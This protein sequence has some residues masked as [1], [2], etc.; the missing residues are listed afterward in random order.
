MAWGRGIDVVVSVVKA[1]T[2]GTAA[3]VNAANL[4]IRV[5]NYTWADGLE[6][7]PDKSF[8]ADAVDKYSDQVGRRHGVIQL[9]FDLKTE[10]L[11]IPL[12]GFFGT[13][14]VPVTVTAHYKHTWYRNNA[15]AGIFD[16]VGIDDG[17]NTH[18]FDSVKWTTLT[19]SSSAGRRVVGVLNGI[20]RERTE[21][22]T[23]GLGS[24]TERTN[25]FHV[26]WVNGTKSHQIA[27]AAS[28]LANIDLSTFNVVFNQEYPI[29]DLS[30][31]DEFIREPANAGFSCTGT[32]TLPHE[33]NTY[34]T[35]GK[36]A[37]TEYKLKLAHDM[38]STAAQ[39]MFDV[40]LPGLKFIDPSVANPSGKGG[41]PQNLS[42]YCTKP[43][44]TPS[45]FDQAVPYLL[46]HNG[47][48]ADARA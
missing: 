39:H 9:T 22:A 37:G 1:A 19:I 4:G 26:Q 8:N 40:Y 41:M 10:G 44:S 12:A 31:T 42:F 48:S 43:A 14:G 47:N 16:S 25:V 3:A 15:M 36:F 17:V 21:G 5:L 2:W 29:D 34:L 46:V 32:V 45:G 38:D 7:I 23:N 20:F 18:T 11:D 6:D 28:S 24:V 35:T 33:V 27:A 13:A 30:Y